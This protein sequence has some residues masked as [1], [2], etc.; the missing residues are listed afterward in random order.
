[1]TVPHV[2]EIP[3]ASGKLSP[4]SKKEFEKKK[5]WNWDNKLQETLIDVRNNV[6]AGI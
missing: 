4:M 1:M 5:K 6:P 3:S 2:H